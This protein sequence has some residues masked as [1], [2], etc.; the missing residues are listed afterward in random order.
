MLIYEKVILT[1]DRP[2]F[3]SKSLTVYKKHYPTTPM[4]KH[5]KQLA[6]YITQNTDMLSKQF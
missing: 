5:T 4:K 3:L 2:V 6:V 1:S